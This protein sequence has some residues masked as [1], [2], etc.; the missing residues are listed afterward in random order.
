MPETEESLRR[1]SIRTHAQLHT[2]TRILRRTYT[3]A[4]THIHTHTHILFI[5]IRACKYNTHVYFYFYSFN[6]LSFDLA[7]SLSLSLS[8]S[9]SR[10]SRSSGRM[11]F[12]S[13]CTLENTS[14]GRK[15]TSGI[16]DFLSSARVFWYHP[17]L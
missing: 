12:I 9:L 6:L 17:R 16:K 10:R 4:R 2:F 7:L 1:S 11:I 14:G 3:R 15:N 5:H 8:F 13:G